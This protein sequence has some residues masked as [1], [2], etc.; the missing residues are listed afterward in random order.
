M[1]VDLKQKSQVTIPKELVKKL[2]LKVGDKLEVT[3]NDG[4]LIVTPVI[5]VPKDQS[6]FYTDKWQEME[7][8]VD[9]QL[10][11]GKVHE[12]NTKEELLKGLGLDEL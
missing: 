11:E 2:N 12:V 4:K 10:A 3:E 5:I 9:N 6:W 1:I 7:K 8:I